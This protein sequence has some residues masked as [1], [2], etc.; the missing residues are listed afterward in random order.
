MYLVLDSINFCFCHLS[1][2][3]ATF[4]VCGSGA[5]LVGMQI[6]WTRGQDTLLLPI[7]SHDLPTYMLLLPLFHVLG[8]MI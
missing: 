7:S 4:L 2:Y 3:S 1:R 5:P 6:F 8:A